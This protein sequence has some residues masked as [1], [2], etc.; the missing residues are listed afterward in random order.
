M[1]EILMEFSSYKFDG[2]IYVHTMNGP[3]PLEKCIGKCC[4]MTHKMHDLDN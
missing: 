3:C 4:R 2:H 1:R